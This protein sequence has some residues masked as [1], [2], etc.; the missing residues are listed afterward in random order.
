M[1]VSREELEGYLGRIA[2]EVRDPRGGIH[3]PDS[4]SWRMGREGVLFLGGGRAALLQL[5][6]PFVA[7]AVDQHSDTRR[8]PAGRFQRTF[9]HVYAM[10][11]GD[12]DHA[13]RSARRVHGIHTRIRGPI[14]ED[15][16]AFAKG[17]RYE[18]NDAQALLWVFATLTD[19]AIQVYDAVV[20]PLSRE[21]R[22]RYYE[23]SKRFAWLFGIPDRVLPADYD[24][25]QRYWDDMLASE[26]IKVGEPAAQIGRFLMA[27]PHPA[28]QPL[29]SWYRVM[30]AG[31]L[32]ERIRAEFGL[33]FGSVERAMFTASLAAIRRVYPRVPAR[34]RHIPAYVE[35]ARRVRG[36]EGPD[37]FGRTLERL[38][39]RGMR[40]ARS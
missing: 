31:F 1:T 9:E 11:F 26:V 6:H 32:P 37:R 12:L 24:A 20:A 5:A 33:A 15:V 3:G 23:E 17:A 14:Q 2:Q 40:A 36:E 28:L 10:V 18:A 22:G 34:L 19:S 8:D 7:H 27:S 16:G 13:F 25:F 30:T 4:M 29:T 35:A 38:L 39:Q 21:E